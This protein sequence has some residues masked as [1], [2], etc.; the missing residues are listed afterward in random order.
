[1]A[2]TDALTLTELGAEDI[3]AALALSDE[4]DW[5][6]T[7]DDWA[8]MLRHGHAVAFRDGGGRPIASALALP[9]GSSLGWLSMVLVAAAWRQQGLATRLVEDCAAW[10]ERRGLAP[11]L[12]ATPAGAAVYGRM[13]FAAIGAL[14]RWTRPAHG[15]APHDSGVEPATAADLDRILA[16]DGAVFGAERRFV[17]A[18]L[19]SRGPVSLIAPE[20]GFLLSRPGRR[21]IQI[22]PVFARDEPSAGRLLEAALA[23][24][25]GPVVLDAF[26]AQAAFAARLRRLGFTPQRSFSRMLRGAPIGFGD[27]VRAFAAA[28]P[29]L[30]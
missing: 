24:L 22:G 5:N 13:G 18:D 1:M 29:E 27:A 7:G 2:V 17:V 21:A 30:G 25:D 10:L 9:M 11:V 20:G 14:T 28:G 26:D 19:L 23:R 4:A 12:D 6:Q 15:E 3:L 8:L 16:Y